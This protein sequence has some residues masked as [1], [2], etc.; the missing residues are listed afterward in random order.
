[1]PTTTNTT[2]YYSNLMRLYTV[3]RSSKG[4]NIAGKI[5]F[6]LYKQMHRNKSGASDVKGSHVPL[7]P[8]ETHSGNV[9]LLLQFDKKNF[10]L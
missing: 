2:H 4:F 10:E 7:A 1:M 6:L 5:C 9:V 8:W 3:L